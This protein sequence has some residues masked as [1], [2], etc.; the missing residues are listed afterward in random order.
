M[1]LGTGSDSAYAL[2]DRQRT[3]GSFLSTNTA[4]GLG[5]VFSE[6]E[7]DTHDENGGNAKEAVE[8]NRLGFKLACR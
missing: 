6:R 8:G 3:Y 2:T 1:Q 4:T 7:T 5:E